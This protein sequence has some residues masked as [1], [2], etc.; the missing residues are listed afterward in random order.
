MLT[1]NKIKHV[2]S[3][4]RSK[5]RKEYN[6]FVVEGEKIVS[7]L[8][9]SDHK[10]KSVFALDS[11]IQNNQDLIERNQLKTERISTKELERISFLKMP[12]KALAV[13][14]SPSY[15]LKECCTFDDLTIVLDTIQD[16]GNLGA[17]I[18]TADWYGIK[19][20]VCSHE[21][22]DVYNPKVV[23]STMG[24]IL[25]V[26][27][28]YTDLKDF[29]NNLVPKNLEVYGALLEGNNLYEEKLITNSI[30]VIG[31]ESKGISSN[32]EQYLT[33]KLR[34]PSVK[35]SKVESLNA[36]VAAAIL[37][38]EFRRKDFI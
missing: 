28:H 11:W 15:N 29:F 6:E 24:S 12:N 37:C 18:R 22:V 34:I 19:N 35:N 30:L 36:S 3:L 27:V 14:E 16:P 31:N 13:V 23:Q 20:I 8:I 1:K 25:R 32:I 38:A 7:E 21:T 26:K 10:V 5:F 17:I 2:Q 9:A 4:K 33:S